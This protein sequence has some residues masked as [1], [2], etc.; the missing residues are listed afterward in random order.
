MSDADNVY[1]PMNH[2][3][4]ATMRWNRQNLSSLPLKNMRYL[5]L[6]LLMLRLTQLPFSSKLNI[7]PD[8][9]EN[10]EDDGKFYFNN[11]AFDNAEDAFNSALDFI[12]KISPKVSKTQKDFRKL[13][14][15]FEAQEKELRTNDHQIH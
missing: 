5:L 9:N 6:P 7:I 15:D 10:D 11:E 4:L 1:S 12:E 8:E 13:K 3:L 2:P 14:R